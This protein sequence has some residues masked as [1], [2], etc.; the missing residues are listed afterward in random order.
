MYKLRQPLIQK[1]EEREGKGV[2]RRV[3]MVKRARIK[4]NEIAVRSK[5]EEQVR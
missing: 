5:G 3:V 1:Q 4:P 2:D